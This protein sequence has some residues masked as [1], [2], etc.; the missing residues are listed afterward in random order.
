M[1]RGRET[2]EQVSFSF[3]SLKRILLINVFMRFE[4]VCLFGDERKW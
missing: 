3:L 2:S 4:C 1:R